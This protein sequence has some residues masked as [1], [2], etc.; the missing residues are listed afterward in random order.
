MLHISL[1]AESEKSGQDRHCAQTVCLTTVKRPR[2]GPLSADAGQR[3]LG[4]VTCGN[5]AVAD[6]RDTAAICRG[7]MISTRLG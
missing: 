6:L 7:P 1:A 3:A 5:N 4:A 2:V